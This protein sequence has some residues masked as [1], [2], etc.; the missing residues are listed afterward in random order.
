MN[1][2]LFSS[3]SKTWSTP[4]SLFE[5]LNAEF[6]FDIDVC[7]IKENAK[8]DRYFSPNDNGLLQEWGG[9]CWM[10]PPYGREIKNWVAKAYLESKRGATVVC[11]LPARSDTAWFHDYCSKAA[12]IRFVKGR[13]HFSESKNSAPFPS[14]IVIFKQHSGNTLIQIGIKPL[15]RRKR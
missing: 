3:D 10:N 13:L 9:I 7:A 15:V 1:K 5:T 6:S 14:M 2:G 12:E 11:L 4:K 8:C